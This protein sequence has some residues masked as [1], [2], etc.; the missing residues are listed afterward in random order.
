MKLP[1]FFPALLVT[2]S[3]ATSGCAPS[4]TMSSLPDRAHTVLNAA[5]HH[6]K[7]FVKVHAAEALIA[8][9]EKDEPHRVFQAELP[10]ANDQRPYRIGVWR[11]LAASA[12]TPQERAAWIARTEAVVLDSTTMDRLH[13]VESLGKLGHA[14]T[15]EVRAALKSMAQGT[16]A[17]AVFPHWVL[18]LAG[19]PTALPAIV[20]ALSSED[21]IARLRAAYVLRWLMITDAPTRA[22]LGGTAR[23]EPP[24]AIGYTIILGSAVTLAADPAQ[25]AHW[26]AILE[27]TLAEGNAG[28]RYD[29]CQTLMR[30]ATAVDFPKFAPLLDQAEGDARIGGAWAILHVTRGAASTPTTGQG[31]TP[32]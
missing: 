27:K 8:L 14:P 5:L 7:A 10:A 28:A 31:A 6:E 1:H 9:G 26:I 13:A 11:V 15:A 18:H 24:T 12:R 16:A 29:A 32:R 3:L 17:A 2:I 4:P 22:A 19:E 30:R 23:A 25:T 20:A 21:P